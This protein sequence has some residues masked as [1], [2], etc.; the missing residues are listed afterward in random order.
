MIGY[1]SFIAAA[2][3]FSSAYCCICYCAFGLI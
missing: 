2:Y 3:S 1:R